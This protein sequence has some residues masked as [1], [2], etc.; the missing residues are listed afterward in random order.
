MTEGAEHGTAARI[1]CVCAALWLL[2]SDGLDLPPV[3]GSRP[4][5]GGGGP[6]S[7]PAPGPQNVGASQI[8][9]H[10]HIIHATGPG[11]RSKQEP[12]EAA[13]KATS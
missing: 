4:G 11:P 12:R 2:H 8:P 7:A 6:S 10:I 9:I 3:V 5:P 13:L 1:V